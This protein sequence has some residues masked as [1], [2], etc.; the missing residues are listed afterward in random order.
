V[1]QVQ[2]PA[3]SG[4]ALPQ[5]PRA[6]LVPGPAAAVL[7]E[8]RSQ[9]AHLQAE[10]A[11][12]AAEAQA[13]AAGFLA[14]APSVTLVAE[15]PVE[16]RAGARAAASSEPALP[17]TEPAEQE[18]YPAHDREA[19]ARELIVKVSVR[20]PASASVKQVKQAFVR[21]LG[22]RKGASRIEL[23][24]RDADDFVHCADTDAVG[25]CLDL[26]AEGVQI[27][28]GDVEAGACTQVPTA[29]GPRRTP[30]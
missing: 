14:E 7:I 19:G 22:Q 11:P 4:P 16:R 29:R 26:F 18:A 6:N 17:A 2:A 23:L 10:A 5:A 8:P 20:V 25:P 30:A 9:G 24:R 12:A 1:A 28:V 3:I 13:P 21:K 15:A 27:E